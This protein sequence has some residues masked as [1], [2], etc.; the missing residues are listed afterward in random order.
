M[1]RTSTFL[2]AFAVWIL[3]VWPFPLGGPPSRIPDLGAG[4]VVALFATWAMREPNPERL[5][6]RLSPSRLLWGVAYVLVLAWEVLRANLDVA[7]RVLHPDL[8]I[9]PGIVRV[10]TTLRTD[11]ARTALANSITLTPGTLTVDLTNDGTMFV[12]W[13]DVTTEEAEEARRRIVVRFE[14]ILARILE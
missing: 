9:R 3:L 13:I 11:A 8:P 1:G 10:R 14:R 4:V 5:G 7:Y 12:H 6:V 2:L